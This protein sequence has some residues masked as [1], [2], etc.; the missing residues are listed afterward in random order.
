M[1]PIVLNEAA[2]DIGLAGEGDA[3]QRRQSMLADASVTPKILSSDSD[4]STLKDLKL[5]FVAGLNDI[6]SERLAAIA[7]AQGILVNVED[8]PHLCDFHVPAAVRR[9]DLILTVSTGGKA[10]GLA[11]LI[12]EWLERKLGAEWGVR[13]RDVAASRATWRGQGHLPAEVARRTRDYV[14]ERDWLA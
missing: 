11:R 10:P 14:R 12:R 7:R 5:L 6:A 1:L 9:G 2:V 13:L 3:F 4:A 8:V